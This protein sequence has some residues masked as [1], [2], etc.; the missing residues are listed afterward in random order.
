MTEKRHHPLNEAGEP[1]AFFGRRSGK[2]LHKGQ[3]ELFREVLP[4]LSITLPEAA[5]LDP[6]TLLPE[7]A[8][9]I[10][11][12]GYGGGEHLARKAAEA[13]DTGFIG[14]E[15]FS[16]GIAKMVQA[17]DENGLANVRL[18]T[19]DALKLLVTLPAASVDAVYLLYPDPWP[20]TRHHKRRF[21]SHT[22][23]GELA[24]VLRPGGT[25]HFATD[26]E[27]YANWTLAHVLR[28]PEFRFET[29]AAGDWHVPYPGWQSTR[30]EDKARREGRMTSFYL[31][32]IRA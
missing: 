17:I 12:I 24:R 6:H 30:Y 31:S 5:P 21:V 10:L 18:F 11:E 25:F 20:K 7:A 23:L 3:D 1:R 9:I 16:G 22:T 2:R 13:P 28:A 15:V 19:D 27:D 14:C 8:R 26:I 29:N 32:F 4:G